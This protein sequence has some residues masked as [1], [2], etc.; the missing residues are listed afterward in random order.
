MTWANFRI[1]SRASIADVVGQIDI[2]SWRELLEDT[3]GASTH[4]IEGDA[5]M[6]PLWQAAKSKTPLV[7][8]INLPSPSKWPEEDRKKILRNHDRMLGEVLKITTNYTVLY[9]T[10]PEASLHDSVDND[11][12]EYEM[13]STLDLEQEPM[14]VDLKRDLRRKS[15]EKRAEP[16][17]PEGPLFQRYQFLNRGMYPRSIS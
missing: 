8:G 10:T 9:T 5:Y 3:C 13:E 2:N 15:Q 12:A 11:G 1:G 4:V 14:H 7:L 6:Y 16:T 17:L